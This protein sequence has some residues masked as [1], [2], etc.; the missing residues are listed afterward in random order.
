MTTS[1]LTEAID[2]AFVDRA[3][4]K[5]LVGNPGAGARYSILSSCIEELMRSGLI[6]PKISLLKYDTARLMAS[7]T[8]SV[9]FQLLKISEKAEN[10][11]GRRLRKLPLLAF[12]NYRLHHPAARAGMDSKV[13]LEYLDQA[14]DKMAE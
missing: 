5:R 13:F 11:S 3:D 2:A 14:V 1:N 6:S 4:V 9:E 10:C 12:S 8:T 7:D